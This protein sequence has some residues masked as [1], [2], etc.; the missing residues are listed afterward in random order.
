MAA[1]EEEEYLD[2]LEEVV[3]TMKENSRSTDESGGQEEDEIPPALRDDLGVELMEYLLEEETRYL[4]SR[5]ISEA[6]DCEASPKK[7]GSRMRLIG[8]KLEL[9]GELSC[10]YSN[11]STWDLDT[12]KDSGLEKIYEEAIAT[13]P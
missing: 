9:N 12:L 3:G 8:E 1:Y 2:R 10:F 6:L 13:T 5:Q 4:K 7:V 11:S